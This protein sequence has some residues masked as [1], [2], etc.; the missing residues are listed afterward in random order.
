LTL[1][2]GSTNTYKTRGR[3]VRFTARGLLN[4]GVAGKNTDAIPH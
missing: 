4:P 2:E 3:F 1:I